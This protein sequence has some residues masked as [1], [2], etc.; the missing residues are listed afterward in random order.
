MKKE[1]QRR[2]AEE[3]ETHSALYKGKGTVNIPCILLDDHKWQ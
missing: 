2:S 1:M 3:E